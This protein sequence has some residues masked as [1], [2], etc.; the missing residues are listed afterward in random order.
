MYIYKSTIYYEQYLLTLSYTQ[1]PYTKQCLFIF[2]IQI[3]KILYHN[4]NSLL[5][6]SCERY[7]KTYIYK[8]KK[9]INM[10]THLTKNS[11][12]EKYPLNEKHRSFSF[13][14]SYVFPTYIIIYKKKNAILNKKK[15]KEKKYY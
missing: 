1:H 5:L 15:K 6:T 10:L 9:F 12:V 7:D 13:A 11:P 14:H 2:F 8:K 4:I 3:Y